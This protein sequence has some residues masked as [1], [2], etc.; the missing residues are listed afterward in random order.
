MVK[1]IT[2]STNAS[3]FYIVSTLKRNVSK[4]H[5]IAFISSQVTGILA[6]FFFLL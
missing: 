3:D 2:S 6:T 1:H 4:F 5:N